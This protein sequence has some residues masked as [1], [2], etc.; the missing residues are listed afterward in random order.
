MRDY[1]F[2]TSLTIVDTGRQR[3][4]K[5][6]NPEGL[7]IRVFADGSVYPSRQL[8]DDFKLEYVT[9]KAGE[10]EAVSFGFDFFD[11]SEWPPLAA[12]PRMIVFGA[13]PK[14]QPKVDLFSA[15]R[16]DDAGVPRSSVMTQGTVST[17]LL[18]LVRSMGYL[19][20][21]QKY[22]DLQILTAFPI[23]VQD[24]IANVPKVVERGE[25]KGEKTYQ[26]RENATF[27]PVDLP[28]NVE[29]VKKEEDKEVL[30]P[31][32]INN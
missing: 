16:Y 4:P 25:N 24:G 6:R 7:A 19:T 22:C 17:A 11:S 20:T 12:H 8:V 26:R 28:E 29:E 9:R 13:V 31:Q 14:S 30:Q 15:C 21:D 1:S 5:Q 23:T 32:N 10:D 3:Q 2:L 18:D 27:Y